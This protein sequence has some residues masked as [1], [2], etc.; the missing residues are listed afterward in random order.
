MQLAV[1]KVG[2]SPQRE[3]K[4]TEVRIPRTPTSKELEEEKESILF[5]QMDAP[6]TGE[7]IRRVL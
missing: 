5:K 1:I 4:G 7:K 6:E 2:K 3:E